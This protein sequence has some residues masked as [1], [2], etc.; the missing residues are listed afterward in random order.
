MTTQDMVNGIALAQVYLT[1]ASR[2]A[3]VATVSAEIDRAEKLCKWLLECRAHPD[4]TMRDV[5]RG[6]RTPFGEVRRPALRSTFWNG[7]DGLRDFREERSF[8]V[9]QG[10]R[11]G[12]SGRATCVRFDVKAAL[13]GVEPATVATVARSGDPKR[14]RTEADLSALCSESSITAQTYIRSSMVIGGR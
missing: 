2:F 9:L 12:G 5:M 3:G 4:I 14:Q 11:S 10:Q 6:G 13:A 7:T 8:A 1:E